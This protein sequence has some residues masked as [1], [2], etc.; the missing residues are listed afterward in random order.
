MSGPVDTRVQRHIEFFDKT[1]GKTIVVQITVD[2]EM[3]ARKLAAK[4]L[5]NVAGKAIECGGA[6]VVLK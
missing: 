3:I 6:V 5:K 4:A 1:Q 2:F